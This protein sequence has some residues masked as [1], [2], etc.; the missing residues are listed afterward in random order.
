M[1]GLVTRVERTTSKDPSIC[2]HSNFDQAQFV[3]HYKFFDDYGGDMDF[4]I[5]QV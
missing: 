4:S 2:D 3:Q 1:Q 5:L